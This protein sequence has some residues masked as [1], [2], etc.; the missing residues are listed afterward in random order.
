MSH[1]VRTDDVGVSDPDRYFDKEVVHWHPVYDRLR[2][3]QIF[4]LV[5]PERV[6]EHEANPLGIRPHFHSDGLQ[7]ILRYFRTQA[8]RARYLVYAPDG[9]TAYR[10]VSVEREQPP[11]IS[12]QRY[13]TFEEALHAIFLHRVEDL[14]AAVAEGKG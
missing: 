5:T 3:E 1:D 12:S 2:Q 13:A 14:R 8:I 10:I 9:E 6:A 11:M 4:R 7:S